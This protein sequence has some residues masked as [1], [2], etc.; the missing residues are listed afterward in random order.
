M[1][2]KL[3]ET[4]WPRILDCPA[5]PAQYFCLI[6]CGTLRDL[7]QFVQFKKRE[8]HPLRSVTLSIVAD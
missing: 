1:I 5:S 6:I 4:G 3:Y 7:G 2:V 8:I